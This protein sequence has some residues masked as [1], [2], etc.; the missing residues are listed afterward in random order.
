MIDPERLERIRI[1]SAERK[2]SVA[3]VIRD[4]IDQVLPA[5]PEARKEA[6]R[7]ILEAEP[8]SVPSPA[9]LRSELKSL[10]AGH[11]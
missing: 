1:R 7:L 9:Q 2:V 11:F 5:Q 10:R 3:E 6:A 4:A 8:M